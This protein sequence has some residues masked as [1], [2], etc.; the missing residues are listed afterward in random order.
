MRSIIEAFSMF[1]YGITPSV[2]TSNP[3]MNKEIGVK[4]KFKKFV[5]S[6]LELLLIKY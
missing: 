4:E 5:L 6:K 1:V 2:T 3:K